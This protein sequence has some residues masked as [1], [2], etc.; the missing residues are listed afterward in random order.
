MPALKKSKKNKVVDPIALE[1][2][3]IEEAGKRRR[4]QAMLQARLQEILEEEETMTAASM[5]AIEA[6]WIKF[7]RE[8]KQKE[9]VASIEVIRRTFESGLDRQNAIISLLFK[10]TDE[11][12]DQYR[13]AYRSHAELV[14]SL[15]ELQN[16]HI[17]QLG[18]EFESDLLELKK[19]YELER[20]ELE[21]NHQ[22]EMADLR[23]ILQNMAAEAE[24]MEKKLQ[25]ERSEAHETA[26]EK[27]D[28]ERKQM[29][30]DLAKTGENIRNELDT[31]YK[32][33]MSTAQ[34]SMKDYMDKSKED[35]EITEKIAAQLKKIDKLQESV[36]SWRTNIARNAREWESR[37]S[38]IQAERDAT[39]RHLKALKNKMQ[40]W[41]DRQASDL[42]D[43]VKNA[44]KAETSLETTSTKAERILRLIELCKPLETEREHVLNFDSN[45]SPQTVEQEVHERV[46][47]SEPGALEKEPEAAPAASEDWQLLERFWTK[48]NK[49]TLDNAAILQERQQLGAENQQLQAILKQYLDDITVNDNV[50]HSA[51]TL[52]QTKAAPN[53]VQSALASGRPLQSYNNVIEANKEVTDIARQGVR[54]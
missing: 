46:A 48:Y 4:E 50:M 12:E 6:R 54:L 3:R 44:K 24:A 36:T 41:R 37:N 39:L 40:A 8:C 23:L 21:R 51:N 34:V 49:V 27:M 18:E 35:Q 19:D 11:A 26:V 53:V 7:L 9:L 2:A 15:V 13:H 22:I 28:E 29:E 30:V 43:L 10:D 32:D 25:E 1:R 14:D 38:A 16:R 20:A 17:Q 42:A 5:S 52:L 33:F 31:R 47:Q 45:A